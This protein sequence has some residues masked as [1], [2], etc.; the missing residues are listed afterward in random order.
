MKAI[1]AFS[2][3]AISLKLARTQSRQ[4]QNFLMNR[5]PETIIEVP[6][7]F[8]S[9]P[10][11]MPY[12]A[13]DYKQLTPLPPKILSAPSTTIV[14]DCSP[15]VCKNLANALQLMIV[16]NLLQRHKG[17]SDLALQLASPLINDVISSPSFSCGCQNPLFQN[18]VPNIG[19]NIARA[20]TFNSA[21]V[22][23]CPKHSLFNMLGMF[24]N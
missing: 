12:S 11:K 20:P 18:Q 10:M 13:I 24:S 16:C 21:P 5:I 19:T 23:T 14:T 1:I 8:I 15:T 4:P 9:P 6:R 17:G 3:V 7:N 2:I 22:N